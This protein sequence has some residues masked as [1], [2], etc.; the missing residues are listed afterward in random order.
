MKPKT[1]YNIEHSKK[2]SITREKLDGRIFWVIWEHFWGE[3]NK[4]AP[5]RKSFVRT[6][7]T[8]YR[9]FLTIEHRRRI[10]WIYIFSR[11]RYFYSIIIQQYIFGIIG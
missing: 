5:K 7:S 11:E 3:N 6:I 8:I 4:L 10:M 1:C 9:R 2:S